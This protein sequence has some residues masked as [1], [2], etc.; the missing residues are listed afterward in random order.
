MVMTAAPVTE[1]TKQNN[2]LQLSLGRLTELSIT[3]KNNPFADIYWPN[4]IPEDTLWMPK[5]LMTVYGTKS[6]ETLSEEDWLRLSKWESI[7]FYSFNV[8]GERH[9]LRDVLDCMHT[10]GYE[11]ISEYMHHFV[12]EENNHSWFFSHFCTRY[13]GKVYTDKRVQF[14]AEMS[15]PAV[16]A[17]LTFARILILEEMLDFYN[18]AIEKDQSIPGIIRQLNRMHHFEES[19]HM[20]FGRM[21]VTELFEK[22]KNAG[23]VENVNSCKTY[24]RRYIAWCLESLY[25]PQMYRDAGIPDSYAFRNAVM[26]DPSRLIHHDAL[27]SRIKTFLV[28]IGAL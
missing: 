28:K 8:H 13:G 7:W 4:S 9:L 2:S 12:S 17:F 27:T 24:L 14:K 15:P 19:R 1:K 6:A 11:N 3:H 23:S 18:V 25:Y 5:H 20:A 22:V 26:A 21:M 10:P 16:Q